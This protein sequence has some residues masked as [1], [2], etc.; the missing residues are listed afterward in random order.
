MC[1]MCSVIEGPVYPYRC[2]KCSQCLICQHWRLG[3]RFWLGLFPWCWQRSTFLTGWPV[4]L[5]FPK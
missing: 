3:T 1:S 4:R 2:P 5:P